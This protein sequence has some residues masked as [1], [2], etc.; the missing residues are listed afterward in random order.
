M[1]RLVVLGGLLL[2]GCG[3]MVGPTR[4]ME[5]LRAAGYADITIK[6]Q[7]GI[8]PTLYGCANGDAVA[9]EASAL[10]PR[11]ERVMTTVCCGLVL[12]DCTIRH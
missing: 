8:A 9:F 4:A 12:K 10:N 11:N 2:C 1:K 7:H 6:A 5:A 3:E